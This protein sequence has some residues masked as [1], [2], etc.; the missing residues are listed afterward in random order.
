M[1]LE[2]F[3]KYVV[4]NMTRATLVNALNITNKLSN[5][6]KSSDIYNASDFCRAVLNYLNNKLTEKCTDVIRIYKTIIATDKCL[7]NLESNVPY[8]EAMVL[9][10]YIIEI[11]ESLNGY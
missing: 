3:A 2:D 10:N 9:D 1:L 8:N 5:T 11:W 6:K 4:D 7:K